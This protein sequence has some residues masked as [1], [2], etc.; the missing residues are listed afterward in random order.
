MIYWRKRDKNHKVWWKYDDETEGEMVFSFDK[1]EEFSFWQDYPH[2]LTPEQK[3]IFDAENE[4][5]VQDLKE[6]P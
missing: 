3:A 4:V 6:Q 2:K 5:L 1:K